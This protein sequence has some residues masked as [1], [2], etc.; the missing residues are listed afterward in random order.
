LNGAALSEDFN[1]L[2]APLLR[3]L[4]ASMRCHGLRTGEAPDEASY[5]QTE[6]DMEGPMAAGLHQRHDVALRVR[7]QA[8]FLRNGAANRAL[9]KRSAGPHSQVAAPKKKGR[10][11]FPGPFWRHYVVN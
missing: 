1:E 5:L 3:L 8:R 2:L 9:R 11:D 7:P 6:D 4:N 10:E